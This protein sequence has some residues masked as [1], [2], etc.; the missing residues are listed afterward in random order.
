MARDTNQRP[1]L[2]SLFMQIVD[3]VLAEAGRRPLPSSGP[4]RAIIKVRDTDRVLQIVAGP[5]S[6]KT[7]M[8][9]WRILYELLVRQTPAPQLIVTT[10]TRRAATELQ[11][12]LV[13]RCDSFLDQA[14]LLGR[15][16]A[17]P[18]VHDVRIGTI[19]SLCDSLLAEFSDAYVANGIQLIDEVEATVRLAREYR[20]VLGHIPG[21]RELFIRL[22]DHDELV[23]LFRPPWED[24]TWP[25]SNM[26]RVEFAKALIAQQVETWKARC[27]GTPRV[28]NG[29][30]SVHGIVG[31]TDDLVE[32]ERRWREDHLGRYNLADFATIQEMFRTHQPGL[33][34]RVRHV[35]VDEF[36]DTNPIQ[37]SIHTAWLASPSIRL[38]V[39]GDDDQAVYRFR[40]SD[41]A[42]FA[43]LEPFCQHHNI[44][45][46]LERLETNYRSTK[47][48]VA[49]TQA[50]RSTTVL[51]SLSM[52]KQIQADNSS[53]QGASVHLLEGTWSDLS[54]AVA[55]EIDRIG[56]GR[57][58]TQGQSAP[59]S[60]AI[61]LFS[62]SERRS[63]RHGWAAPGLTIR[64]AI[65]SRGIRVYNPRNKTAAQADS[66]V[67]MLLGLLSYLVDPVTKEPVGAGGRD[68]MV[69]ASSHDPNNSAALSQVPG[70]PI[71]D[72]HVGFQKK[73]RNAGGR[74]I[75][76]T[77]PDRQ[78]LL[79][80]LDTLRDNLSRSGGSRSPRLTIAGLVYRL[81][82]QPFF[83]NS[84]FTSE[85]FRQA[86]FTQLM[87]A[88]IAPT[89]LTTNSLD[90][91]LEVGRQGGKYVWPD[92][93]WDFLGHFGAL[94][95]NAT[96]D[97]IEVESFEDN[98]VLLITF[99][100]AKG[101]EFDHVYVAGMGRSPDVTPVLRT[102]LFS[103]EEIPYS[104]INRS[105]TTSDPTVL[106]LAQADRER[107]VYV[108]MTRA[109]HSL[110]LLHDP[111]F[112]SDYMNG[113]LAITQLFNRRP[114]S[115]HPDVP[116]VSVR[117]WA[118]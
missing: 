104:V 42:C 48:I 109:R 55:S 71:N 89:R 105:V 69:W 37:F 86:L 18:H 111:S 22:L 59:P 24:N 70:H 9:V 78:Q 50:F 91:P 17:D 30:E 43:G 87:E 45:H 62:T 38:T 52:P 31:L 41:L 19:H 96:M 99:H 3:T 28:N 93:F 44:A 16:V 85:M 110:T 12:R 101:L 7:E 56:A 63:E 34:A 103:G 14:R 81:L 47:N 95:D 4:Q 2:A 102:R 67:G 11:V 79:T 39:V 35:F 82:A 77:P 106:G 83:R 116:S 108:A 113:N 98:A 68:V 107:E 27:D 36:Q 76:P 65:E 20:F 118:P 97:D 33:L 1:N 84:G 92:R 15:E 73:F 64:H 46:R 40:G 114:S 72:K 112:G 57:I 115:A 100:Q 8:L 25:T 53:S 10:F 61:L 51:S 117:E 5:G 54:R 6:G 26:E 66:S 75:G 21:R 90:Q 88:N 23:A 29:I 74:G 94:L 60:V 58:P 32:L 13:E 49:F 80:L